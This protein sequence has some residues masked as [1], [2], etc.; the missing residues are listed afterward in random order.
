MAELKG[1]DDPLVSVLF[2]GAGPVETPAPSARA[3]LARDGD[4]N[5]RPVLVKRLSST[6]LGRATEALAL[7][8]P[9]IVP[10]RRWLLGNGPNSALYVVRDVVRGRNLRQTLS[11]LP[12]NARDAQTMQRLFSPV[13]DALE[14]AHGQNFAHGGVSAENIFVAADSQTV[15]VSDWASADPKSPQHFLVYQGTASV[16]GDVRALARLMT[17]FLPAAGAFASPAVRE[18]IAGVLARSQ[19]LANLR[20]TLDA[21]DG[22]A[23]APLP[24]ETPGRGGGSTGGGP[25]NFSA[26]RSSH[27]GALGRG[28]APLDL[29]LNDDATVG[30]WA[31]RLAASNQDAEGSEE[32]TDPDLRALNGGPRGTQ[33]AS[34]GTPRLV[35]TLAEKTARAPAGGGGTATL[36][37]RNEG[38]APLTIRMIATQHPWLNVRPLELPLTLSPGEQAPVGFAIS[39]ARLSPGD[40]RSEVYLSANAQ[41]KRAEDLR[42]G[43]FKHTA[44][45]RVTVD[46]GPAFSST[47]APT[48]SDKPAYP[49]NAPRIPASGPG[50]L[51]VVP[52]LLIALL[53]KIL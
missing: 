19:T 6:G 30:D 36:L 17:E 49:A 43:W 21:L 5:G 28:P 44:E 38:D 1:A 8:H 37:V 46:G 9:H 10:T 2:D 48:G 40:Y 4:A 14:Y 50:C 24:R 23:G 12:A 31:A 34:A 15:L 53:L 27:Q 52:A 26:A 45:V 33:G 7:H 18:R 11:A 42:G 39:A 3:W 41:A 13:L 35:C 25:G 20:E 47:P 51:L 22:L 29:G 16:V 32:N